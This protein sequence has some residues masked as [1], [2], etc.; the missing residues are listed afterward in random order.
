MAD[1]LTDG[2]ESRL[3]NFA[4]GNAGATAPT[5]PLKAR[6]MTANGSDSAN[7]T[8]VAGGTYAA[9]SVAFPASSA[10]AAVTNSA[11]ADAT[12]MPNTDANPIVGV[13]IWDSAGTPFRWWWGPLSGGSYT[14][15]ASTDVFTS[16]AHGL[17]NGDRVAFAPGQ[18]P[19]GYSANVGYYVVASTTN[20]FQLSATLGGS[21]VNGTADGS[22]TYIRARATASGDTFR[23]AAGT[24]Q[25]SIT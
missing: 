10:G 17:A 18:A 9:P 5:L 24:L 6:L 7:G 8:E 19:T 15:V 14:F 21:A 12:G 25:L 20:T 1:N 16:A 11:D 2:A 4:T 22:G 3:L 13:E 23:I